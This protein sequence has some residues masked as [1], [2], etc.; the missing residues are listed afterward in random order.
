LV[1]GADAGLSRLEP[2][3][4]AWQMLQAINGARLTEME[5]PGF[6]VLIAHAI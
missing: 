4:S 5:L 3:L 6:A 2:D 1:S